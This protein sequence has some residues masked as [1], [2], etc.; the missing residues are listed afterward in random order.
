MTINAFLNG[1]YLNINSIYVS[2]Q[3]RAFVF[4]DGIYEFI[5]IYNNKSFMLE[6]HLERLEESASVV[7]IN[8]PYPR[9]G[10]EK[11]IANLIGASDLKD[12]GVYL[13][14]TRG[15]AP[16]KHCFPK[17]GKPTVFA[18]IDELPEYKDNMYKNG[19]NVILLPDERWKNCNIKTVNLLPNV[20]AKEKA[21]RKKAFEAVLVND[22]SEVTEGS[23]SN[24]FA[25]INGSLVT[26]PVSRRILN[27]I[28]RQAILKIAHSEKIP[29]AQRHVK[30]KE[31]FVADEVFL[32]S[33]GM[34]VMPVVGVDKATVGD[35][36]PGSITK[37][38][39]KRYNEIVNCSRTQAK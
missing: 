19:V 36:K 31:L 13:Q 21:Y 3:D 10:F 7:E 27:G 9:Q 26:A 1:E 17:N 4:G 5:S 14:I 12:A 25:V 18:M 29:V 34:G 16:R 38:L 22:K 35:G 6:E 8:L 24:V 37:K 28:T 23:S 30:K 11:L 32:T 33:T 15:V 2:P 20:I 39:I